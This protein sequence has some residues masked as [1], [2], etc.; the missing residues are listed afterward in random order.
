MRSAF[1][2]ALVLGTFG[3]VARA[4]E[5][6]VSFAYVPASAVEDV[7]VEQPLG[8]LSVR[9]WDRP[10]VRIAATKRAPN[11]AGLDRLR[12]RVDLKDGKL[13]V[14]TGVRVGEV[15]RGIPTDAG[16]VIDLAVDAPS[17]ARIHAT[18]FDGDL[19]ALGFRAG[20]VLSSTNG[21]IHATDIDGP[22][23]STGTRGRQRLAAIRGDVDAQS[24]QGALELDSIEG[25]VLRA[26]V[27][28]GRIEARRV[29][30]RVVE[31]VSARG[32]VTLAGAM[33]LGARWVLR[34]PAGDGHLAIDGA[35]TSLVLH[36]E[37]GL[38][39][40]TLRGS[41]PA[42]DVLRDLRQPRPGSARLVEASVSG[43][44]HLATR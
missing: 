32:D 21:E 42:G 43:T 36:A 7:I 10:E 12:V 5:T 13:E 27:V 40:V 16:Y 35:P 18:T 11:H 14:L 6:E 28:D 29:R 8:R 24:L 4:E 44:L 37:R 15:L 25:V 30:A 33:P 39:G 1:V 31:L 17:G 19:D 38:R 34:A 9:G 3:G 2:A 23:R 22:V 26:S 41:R 20:V